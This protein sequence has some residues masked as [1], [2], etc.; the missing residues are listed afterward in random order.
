M[1]GGGDA[2]GSLRSAQLLTVSGNLSALTTQK[3]PP[4][5]VCESLLT[6]P[7]AVLHSEGP[8][9]AGRPGTGAERASLDHKFEDSLDLT[10]MWSVSGILAMES[11]LGGAESF[12]PV[13]APPTTSP[14]PAPKL[15]ADPGMDPKGKAPIDI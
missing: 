12:R 11:F 8:T 3:S 14:A 15:C 1:V 6:L 13:P 10:L 5:C 4:E 2:T 7:S 9:G